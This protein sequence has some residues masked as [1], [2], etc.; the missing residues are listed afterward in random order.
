MNENENPE[1]EFEIS[2]LSEKEYIKQVENGLESIIREEMQLQRGDYFR[3]GEQGPVSQV[4]AI[5]LRVGKG[6]FKTCDTLSE[7]EYDWDL[8]ALYQE[9]RRGKI[10]PVESTYN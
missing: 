1:P 9:W 7:R 4:L 5:D 8:V 10:V 2:R 6:R 3:E